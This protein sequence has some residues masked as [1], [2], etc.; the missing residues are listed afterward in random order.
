VMGGSAMG[1]SGSGAGGSKTGAGGAARVTVCVTVVGWAV[2]VTVLVRV[3]EIG[4]ALSLSLPEL[5]IAMSARTPPTIIAGTSHFGLCD[6]LD[7]TASKGAV[8]G[9]SGPAV[10]GIGANFAVQPPPSK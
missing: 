9:G 4:F 10:A 3:D 1:G 5:P 2:T 7:E 6:H 8:V